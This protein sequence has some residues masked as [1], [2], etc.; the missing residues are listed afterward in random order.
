MELALT[1][2]MRPQ[3]SLGVS[4]TLIASTQLLALGAADLAEA[5]RREL[6]DNPAL[7]PAEHPACR[8]CGS[9]S[10]HRPGCP[11]GRDGESWREPPLAGEV[12]ASVAADLAA[13][14]AAD[15][16]ER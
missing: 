3:Q 16:A 12:A 7:V 4:P 15:L 6:E 1:P 2:Q 5:V 8:V 14:V 9:S 13:S 11:R 10:G